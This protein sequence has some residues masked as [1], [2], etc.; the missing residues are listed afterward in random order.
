MQ[1]VW[2]RHRLPVYVRKT[3][4]D[5]RGNRRWEVRSSGVCRP[6]KDPWFYSELREKPFKQ[7]KQKR[8]IIKRAIL[9]VVL[10]ID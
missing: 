10:Q 3:Q 6:L 9:N 1:S 4:G 7:L 8:D 5:L 2:G